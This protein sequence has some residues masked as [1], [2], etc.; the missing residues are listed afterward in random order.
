LFPDHLIIDFDSTFITKESLDELAHLVLLNHKDGVE[1]LK[2]IKALTLSGMEGKIPFDLS[3]E[4]RIALINTNKKDIKQISSELSKEVSPSIKKNKLFIKKNSSN[5]LIFS[6]GF[7]EIIIPIVSE[8]G[9]NEKQIFANQFIYDSNDNVI[10]IDKNN[11]MS[12]KSGKVL[13]IKALKLSGKIDVI[14]DGFTD[15]EIKKSGLASNFYAFIE[16]IN[17]EKISQ[18]SDKALNSFDD[19]INIVND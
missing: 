4:K 7:K 1:R 18:L 13:M 8:Y 16:N 9:I 2:S 3:L 10:G 17:R 11:N 14:G 5:I 15:Y 12:K 6:G 19:Y